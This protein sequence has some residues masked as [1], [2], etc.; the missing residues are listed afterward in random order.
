MIRSILGVLCGAMLVASPAHSLDE[1]QEQRLSEFLESVS[2]G[3]VEAFMECLHPDDFAPMATSMLQTCEDPGSD[4]CQ[5]LLAYLGVGSAED[6]RSYSARE[7]SRLWLAPV[8]D[9]IPGVVEAM[10]D[11]MLTGF[12]VLE[13]LGATSDGEDAAHVVLRPVT[14]AVDRLV[15]L[16]MTRAEG[17]WFVRGSEPLDLVDL[18]HAYRQE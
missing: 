1:E 11:N 18:I 9:Q 10:R 17:E 4:E 2:S 8:R 13:V 3:D 7:L 5:Q 15:V 12:P 6:L 14:S 16:T